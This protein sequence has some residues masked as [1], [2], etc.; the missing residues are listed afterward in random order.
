MPGL[1]E[2]VISKGPLYPQIEEE[3]KKLKERP[4]ILILHDPERDIRRL[5]SS[6]FLDENLVVFIIDPEKR[7]L[8]LPELAELCR[9]VYVVVC[10]TKE[11]ERERY[12]KKRVISFLKTHGKALTDKAYEILSQR[13]NDEAILEQ[14]LKKLLNY[15]GERREI[16]SKD[17]L[18]LVPDYMEENL[19]SLLDALRTQ[20]KREI[21]RVLRALEENVDSPNLV[22]SYLIRLARLML[23]AKDL[24]EFLDEPQFYEGFRKMKGYLG[25]LGEEKKNYFPNLNP[26][27]AFAIY[28]LAKIMSPSR[29]SFLFFSLTQLDVRLKRGTK[30]ERERLESILMRVFGV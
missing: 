14:E 30:L 12:L 2:R 9:K 17:V 6:L 20:D 5:L 21:T 25:N 13:V 16:R 26:K 4:K 28:D 18:D 3:A 29:L 15:V 1:I 11:E 23:Q 24:R 27:Y 7:I 10:E 19:I 22:L 8:S